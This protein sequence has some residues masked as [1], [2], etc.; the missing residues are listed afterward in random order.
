MVWQGSK[1]GA[2]PSKGKLIA[3]KTSLTRDNSFSGEQTLKLDELSGEDENIKKKQN[4][5]TLNRQSLERKTSTVQS[6]QRKKPIISQF[7]V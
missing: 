6:N 7:Q 2:V 1:I 4:P 5:Q 3:K